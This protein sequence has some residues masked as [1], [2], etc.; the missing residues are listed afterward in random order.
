[1]FRSDRGRTA[2]GVRFPSA[3]LFASTL[4]ALLSVL[5]HS[6]HYCIY[7]LYFLGRFSARLR[8]IRVRLFSRWHIINTY[9]YA[10]FS[11]THLST[12]VGQR[13]LDGAT[14][15]VAIWAVGDVIFQ[16]IL[17]L[18]TLHPSGDCG[19]DCESRT[20]RKPFLNSVWNPFITSNF[21]NSSY[22]KIAINAKVKIKEDKHNFSKIFI[23]WFKA[24]MVLTP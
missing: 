9:K 4:I 15:A 12:D 20:N 16:Y 21:V 6:I 7:T 10:C 14:M 17:V 22:P 5:L 8:R 18:N 3:V 23:F 2:I 19:P 1:M 24:V 11:L 13:R